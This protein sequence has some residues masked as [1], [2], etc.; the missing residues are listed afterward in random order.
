[1][2]HDNSAMRCDEDLKSVLKALVT[3]YQIAK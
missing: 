2:K 1:M 3:G